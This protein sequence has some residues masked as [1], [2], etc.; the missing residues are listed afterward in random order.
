M[1]DYWINRHKKWPG[2]IRAVGSQ[3]LSDE[4]NFEDYRCKQEHLNPIVQELVGDKNPADLIVWDAGCGSGYFTEFLAKKG[5]ILFA[6]DVSEVALS[7]IPAEVKV[8]SK[9]AGPISATFWG[10]P[11]DICFCLD[12]LYHIID[13]REWERSL[14]SMISQSHTVVILEHLVPEPEQPNVHIRYRTL[15]T[16]KKFSGSLS[17]VRHATLHL[18]KSKATLDLL[19]FSRGA[20]KK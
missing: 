17:L 1:S 6:S 12:V 18:P 5:F 19:V 11:I 15:E 20:G 14:A 7:S 3:G 2:S 16:Y 8:T 10:Y 4:D 13:D 9:K